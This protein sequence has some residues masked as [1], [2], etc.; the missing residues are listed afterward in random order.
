M[1]LREHVTGTKGNTRTRQRYYY[2]LHST[3]QKVAPA[4]DLLSRAN[5]MIKASRSA[6]KGPIAKRPLAAKRP[7]ARKP[8]GGKK[9]PCKI[10]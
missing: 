1:V 5:A 2:N 4:G 3:R 7:A 10:S 9:K 8:V 6:S